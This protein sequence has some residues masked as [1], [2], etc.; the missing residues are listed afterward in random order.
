MYLLKC[1]HFDFIHNRHKLKTIYIF[2]NRRMKKENMEH[3][4][5]GVLLSC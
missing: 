2:I 4:H 5:D 1:V 3:L